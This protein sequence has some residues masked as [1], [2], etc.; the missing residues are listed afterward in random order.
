MDPGIF[1]RGRVGRGVQAQRTEK[2]SDTVILGISFL[3]FYRGG[4]GVQWFVLR[5]TIILKASREG[6]TFSGGG[7]GGGGVQTYR[8]GDF[9]GGPDPY[10]L[11]IHACV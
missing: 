11:W 8:I 6:L 1:V 9:P 2:N 4:V 10:P 5:K 3:Q 7:G